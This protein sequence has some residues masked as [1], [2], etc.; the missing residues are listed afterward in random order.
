M[1]TLTKPIELLLV[2]D[3]IAD[4]HIIIEALRAVDQRTNITQARDGQ[5]AID[6][7]LKQG[8]YSS[9]P[10][11]D[12]VILDLNLPKVNGF[13]VLS[14]I[15]SRED[16]K[17]LPVVVMT[18]SLNIEDEVRS[19]SMG[20]KEY[21]SK[22]SEIEEFEVV[23]EWF[24]E[25]FAK[26]ADENEHKENM[27]GPSASFGSRKDWAT[28]ALDAGLDLHAENSFFDIGTSIMN[29]F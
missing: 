21:L 28:F 18:G 6:I 29:H 27:N 3:S 25:A 8:R 20:I 15:R 11:L 5:Q 26:L 10:S 14:L 16:L 12:F 13:E 23:C 7:L 2:E 17:N 19:R 9:I 22:P 4:A 1:Q 24:K